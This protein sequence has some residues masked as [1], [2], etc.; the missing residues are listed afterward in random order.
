MSIDPKSHIRYTSVAPDLVP[1]VISVLGG[2]CF[3]KCMGYHDV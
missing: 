3:G 1:P 2:S